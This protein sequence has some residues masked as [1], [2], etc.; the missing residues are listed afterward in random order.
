MGV[1]FR[2]NGLKI[3]K[4]IMGKFASIIDSHLVGCKERPLDT[5]RATN[6]AKLAINQTYLITVKTLLPILH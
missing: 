3:V 4:R 2:N 5:H 6:S 1:K